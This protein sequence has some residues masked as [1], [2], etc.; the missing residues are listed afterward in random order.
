MDVKAIL[1][2]LEASLDAVADIGASVPLLPSM[3]SDARELTKALRA[4]IEMGEKSYEVLRGEL[5]SVRQQLD[6]LARSKKLG[7]LEAALAAED[8]IGAPISVSG[9]DG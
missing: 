2:Q 4:E 1:Q 7:A 9:Q 8:E 5:Y 3:I 6:A